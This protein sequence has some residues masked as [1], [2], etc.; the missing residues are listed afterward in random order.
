MDQNSDVAIELY[1]EIIGDL[2]YNFP[3]AQT[4]SKMLAVFRLLDRTKF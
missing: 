4:S 1:E 3:W 2:G